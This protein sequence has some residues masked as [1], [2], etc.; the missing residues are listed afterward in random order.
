MANILLPLLLAWYLV[1]ASMVFYRL[2]TG[3][4]ATR[5]LLCELGAGAVSPE[6]VQ[7]LVAT[8]VALS[9]YVTLTLSTDDPTTLPTPPVWVI[10][11]LGGS[12]SL[13]LAGKWFR[14]PGA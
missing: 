8:M 12:Q 11:L 6:R 4:I 3:D 7:M 5:G 14:R 9:S 1:F 13:Y 2:L 10:A